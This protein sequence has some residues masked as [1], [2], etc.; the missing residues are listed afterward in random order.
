MG[1][2]LPRSGLLE[3]VAQA[4]APYVAP[5]SSML[6]VINKRNILNT[7]NMEGAKQYV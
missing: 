2:N 7:P 4:D 3:Q 1:V 5:L 6:A